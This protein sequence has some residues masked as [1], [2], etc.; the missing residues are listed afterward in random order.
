MT[1][2]EAKKLAKLAND[3]VGGRNQGVWDYAK[4]LEG[5]YGLTFKKALKTAM[6]AI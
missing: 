2:T 1:K 3:F 6:E 4:R 5:K